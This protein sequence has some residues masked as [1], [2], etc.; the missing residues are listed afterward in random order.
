MQVYRDPFLDEDINSVR[1]AVY[2]GSVWLNSDVSTDTGLWGFNTSLDF[3]ANGLPAVTYHRF[4][5]N[6]V[7]LA[8][9]NGSSWSSTQ[10]ARSGKYSSVLFDKFGTPCVATYG[11]N[12]SNQ[13]LYYTTVYEGEVSTI[14]LDTTGDVGDYNS[15]SFDSMGF[16]NISYYDQTNGDLKFCKDVVSGRVISRIDENGVVGAYTSMAHGPDLQPAITYRDST[17]GSVKIARRRNDGSWDLATVDS[18]VVGGMTSLSFGP[19]GQPAVAYTDSGE[20]KFA[21]LHNGQWQIS[22]VDSGDE[23]SLIFGPSGL[24][25]IAYTTSGV[26]KFAYK[27]IFVKKQ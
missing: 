23:P 20:I 8:R 21:T 25:A 11:G 3:D 17:N 26:L 13:G 22:T 2:N 27:G 9:Y 1:Y 10:V 18:D 4:F 15:F 12:E 24:P 6:A 5:S 7:I 19:N 16:K 14:A